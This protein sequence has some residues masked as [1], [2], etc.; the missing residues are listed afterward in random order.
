M[1]PYSNYIIDVIRKILFPIHL[2]KGDHNLF[3]PG[4]APVSKAGPSS[5]QT[6]QHVHKDTK[7]MS[8]QPAPSD[9]SLPPASRASLFLADLRSSLPPR[10]YIIMS[11][12]LGPSFSGLLWAAYHLGADSSHSRTVENIN[13][14]EN[15]DSGP[16][17]K[18]RFPEILLIFLLLLFALVYL[19][20]QYKIFEYVR[21][22]WRK[23]R[24]EEERRRRRVG[25]ATDE[26]DEVWAEGERRRDELRRVMAELRGAGII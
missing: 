8:A 17:K 18:K 2:I 25:R 3:Q 6:N 7:T 12:L 21:Q 14:I 20:L 9:S 16:H 26:S 1:P 10:S 15:S 4:L 24:A 19:S 11:L 5:I 22:T 23:G 13:T